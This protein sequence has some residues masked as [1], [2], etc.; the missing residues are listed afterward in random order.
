MMTAR[1][2][3]CGAVIESRYVAEPILSEW[4]RELSRFQEYDQLSAHMWLHISDHHPNQT[5]QG[6]LC[7]RRAAKMYAMNWAT[8]DPELDPLK[9]A[10]R[11]TLIL[12]MTITTMT[13]N[14]ADAA[15]SEGDSSSSDGSGS[16]EKKSV[17][18]VSS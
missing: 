18:K 16:N 2:Q 8:T 17:R 13:E 1:C 10:W 4:D 3:L 11:Q 14:Q 5:E 9:L 7:Q 6:I 15:V 12:R